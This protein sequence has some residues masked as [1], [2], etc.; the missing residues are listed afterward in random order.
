[1]TKLQK[2]ILS[3]FY[4]FI[5]VI[6]IYVPHKMVI[7]GTVS[8]YELNYRDHHQRIDDK[9]VFLFDFTSEKYNY[10]YQYNISQNPYDHRPGSSRN[11]TTSIGEINYYKMFHEILIVTLLFIPLYIISKR[12]KKIVSVWNSVVSHIP[13]IKLTLK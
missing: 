6:C 10:N 13:I 7:T 8:G 12:E 1:M 3:A 4:I 9:Y 11:L 5:F 2:I